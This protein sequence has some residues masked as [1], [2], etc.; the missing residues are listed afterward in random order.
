MNLSDTEI[1]L[2]GAVTILLCVPALLRTE[3]KGKSA[4]VLYYPIVPIA[5]YILYELAQY[6]LAQIKGE[7]EGLF[8]LD[9]LVIWPFLVWTLSKTWYRWMQVSKTT[10]PPVT[11]T[12]ELA[13]MAFL[14]G[15]VGFIPP[16]FVFFSVVAIVCGHKA[17]KDPT[18]FRGKRLAGMGLLAGYMGL[19]FGVIWVLVNYLVPPE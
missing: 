14:N 13:V 16:Y 7:G 1:Q 15:I 19:I 5:V 3:V 6:E 8:R 10:E 11:T 18:N 12:S 2:L 17:I 4:W 9:L